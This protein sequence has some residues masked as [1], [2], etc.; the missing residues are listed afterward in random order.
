EVTGTKAVGLRREGAVATIRVDSGHRANTPGTRA[1]QTLAAAPC[2]GLDA[3]TSGLIAPV[4]TQPPAAIRAAKRA[5]RTIP[6]S[7]GITA[8]TYPSVSR[9][10][11]HAACPLSLPLP[12][13]HRRLTR[14]RLRRIPPPA[15]QSRNEVF[16]DDQ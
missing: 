1:R 3:A 16:D 5:A 11:Q 12:R 13:H 14:D 4:T 7:S 9:P 2:D 10:G 8:S 6:D 15:A